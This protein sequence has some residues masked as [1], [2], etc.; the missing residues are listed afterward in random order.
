LKKKI[1]FTYRRYL[2]DRHQIE[3]KGSG[4]TFK[5][6]LL[7]LGLVVAIS[8]GGPYSIWMVGS[9][10]MTWSY[11]PILVGAPL[12][13]VVLLNAL[14]KKMREA[15][16]LNAAE[17]VTIVIMGLVASGMPIFI[18]G[19]ILSIVSKPYYGA[20]PENDWARL[21]QPHLPRWAIPDPAEDAMRFFYEGLP[22]EAL[23]I[24][25]GAWAGPL[26][27]W[28]ALVLA[29][30]FVGF[31]TVVVLRRHWMQRERLSFPLTEVALMLT[32][33]SPSSVWPPVLKTRVFWIGFA[34][35]FTLIAFNIP[36]YFHLG[37]VQ[38][39]IFQSIPFQLIPHVP[40]V[41]LLI[42]FPVLGFMYLVP[43]AISFSVW[44]FYVLN[45]GQLS[46]INQIGT[47]TLRS[48]PFVYGGTPLAWQS[49]G[50]FVAMVGWSLWMAR[51][52]LVAVW[53]TALGR[54]G[55]IDD[56]DEM[57]SYRVAVCGGFAGLFFILGWLYYSG[58]E[59]YL[60]VLYMVSAMVVFLGITR[61]V[62]QAGMH[63]LTTP[64]SAQGMT[65]AITGSAVEPHSL[66]ALAL[67]FAWCG[68][69]QSTFMPSAAN[70]LKLHDYYT[71]RRNGGLALAIGLAV[72][73]SFVAT[74]GFM[75]Y[76]CYDYG[77]SNLRSWFFNA[78][79]GAGGR[80]FDWVTQQL[81]D[82]APTDWDKLG[83]FGGGAF[84]YLALTFLHYRFAWW[85]LHPVGLAVA[86]TWMV[87]R[88][89]F[90]V[91]LAWACKRLI[92]RF[93]GVGLYLRFKPLF[94]GMVVGFF[95][96]V[97]VSFAIDYFWF[98]GAGHPILHG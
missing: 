62:V 46:L 34:I 21:I 96:G 97:F 54:P 93:G 66:V 1:P 29:L 3:L 55:Q 76:L 23:A 41:E 94:L 22:D 56:M 35:P 14:L 85:S 51:G 15:Y 68:D 12:F 20:M 42:Y 11:F 47:Y 27:W 16:A 25:W 77:A 33:E 78:S 9:S 69:V 64:M 5:A 10:E 49:W 45:L 73:V 26:L 63:Y 61:L 72:V 60:A 31:C 44:F 6:V 58:V 88:I 70:A 86:S 50:A 37:L 75:I 65:M 81:R 67:T 52:H 43:T 19:L 84:V 98:M 7:G 36:S 24:P 53:Q 82:P 91:F 32:E 4:L 79:G 87:R 57:V 17:L 59:L 40:A 71:H 2:D 38:V 39:P 74:S 95:F 13:I 83:F 89:A 48:D 80:A 8:T 30:Y 92:L 90:S 28:L 18:V